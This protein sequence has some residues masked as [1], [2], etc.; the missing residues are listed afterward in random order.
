MSL[1]WPVCEEATGLELWLVQ[2]TCHL[3]QGPFWAVTGPLCRRHGHVAELWPELQHLT[4][5]A[6]L[7]QLAQLAPGHAKG[8]M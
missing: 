7:V 5:S 3:T 4:T 8:L 1:A 6:T 2:A